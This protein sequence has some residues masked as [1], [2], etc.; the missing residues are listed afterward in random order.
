MH[1]LNRNV[2]NQQIVLEI[3]WALLQFDDASFT[4]G[5]AD[6]PI[7]HAKGGLNPSIIWFNS[8]ELWG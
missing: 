8:R 7:V 6:G 1:V 4:Q 5:R 3:T 2:Y